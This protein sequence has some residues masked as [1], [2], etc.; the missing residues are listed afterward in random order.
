MAA[1]PSF[2]SLKV[3]QQPYPQD[4][5]RCFVA[6]GLPE[7]VAATGSSVSDAAA[8]T[9]ATYQT[10]NVTGA[11]GVKGF[12]L[13]AAPLNGDT[14]VVVNSASGVL[15]VY[16]PTGSNFTGLAANVGV[17]L[18]PGATQVF[19]YNGTAIRLL[20]PGVLYA[21]ATATAAGLTTGTI[22]A[23]P[24]NDL[25]VDVTSASSSNQIILPAPVPGTKVTIN[26]GANG[27]DLKSS[28]P[29]TVAINGGTGASAKSAVGANVTLLCY[30]VSTTK[31]KVL[32]LAAAG[33]P[34]ALAAAA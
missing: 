4:L 18:A 31:W 28:A 23:G 33:T 15:W 20:S 9:D 16:P 1:S 26:V 2:D 7:T 12:I 19:V 34:T 11:D 3:P 17:G 5:T 22:V 6:T 10:T 29:A 21:V 13:P 30:C 14:R 32:A 8:N 24:S 25:F 27:Y